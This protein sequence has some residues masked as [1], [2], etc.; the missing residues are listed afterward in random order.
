MPDVST[1]SSLSD[2]ASPSDSTGPAM[3]DINKENQQLKHKAASATV[4]SESTADSTGNF[5][6]GKPADRATDTN[7]TPSSAAQ[8]SS[9]AA[10]SDLPEQ[11]AAQ[12]TIQTSA[13]SI[14]QASVSDTAGM[15]VPSSVPARTM[16]VMGAGSD[17][18][19]AVIREF[20]SDGWSFHLLARN[21]DSLDR[22]SAD[23]AVRY[24]VR[25]TSSTYDAAWDIE[26]QT[27]VWKEAMDTVAT[28]G[29]H[30]E[31]LFCAVGL[32]GNQKEDE[33][34]PYT[35]LEVIRT[36]FT[37]LL[38][39]LSSAALYFE[40]R[41]Q[42][43]L[44][45]I[46]SVAGLRGRASNYIYGSAKAGLNAWLSGARARLAASGVQVL[47]VMPGFVRTKMTAGL[48]LPG[49]LCATPEQVARDIKKASDK[50]SNVIYSLWFW[51]FI[52]AIIIHIPEFIFKKLRNL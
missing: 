16:V 20:A 3:S 25:I 38:P 44:I 36:N 29:G 34:N 49:K 26:R 45:V 42:G 4:T 10:A 1:L 39:V 31:A 51:R 17:I 37:G 27:A 48:P 18:A 19:R 46:S 7:V 35:E 9:A 21:Q 50:G 6:S 8:S 52:M 28:G 33:K 5:M 11:S 14:H 23:T 22:I 40:E 13:E 2:W 32:L 41:R 43:K 47:T 12:A 30:I 15:A 24:G